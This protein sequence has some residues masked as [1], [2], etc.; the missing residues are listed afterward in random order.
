MNPRAVLVEVIG[1][2]VDEILEIRA[3]SKADIGDK[4]TRIEIAMDICDAVLKII[5]AGKKDEKE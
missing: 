1:G 5:D 2:C 4:D 3:K